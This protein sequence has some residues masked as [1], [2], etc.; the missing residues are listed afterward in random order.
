[1]LGQAVCGSGVRS[2]ADS[3]S[4]VEP[5]DETGPRIGHI[6]VQRRITAVPRQS[7]GQQPGDAGCP[8]ATLLKG[9]QHAGDT[10]SI[11]RVAPVSPI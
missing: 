6:A 5:P 8:Y 2:P 4:P 3:S 10:R 7:E 1:M 11:Q 9:G